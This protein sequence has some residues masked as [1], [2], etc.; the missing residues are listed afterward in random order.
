MQHDL[1]I[2]GQNKNT[3][4][5]D[6]VERKVFSTSQQDAK[7]KAYLIS[8]DIERNFIVLDKTFKQTKKHF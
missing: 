7:R 5:F 2:Y 3:G 8:K 4:L 6:T 1:I